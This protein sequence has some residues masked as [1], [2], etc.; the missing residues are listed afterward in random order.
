[1]QVGKK[2]SFNFKDS[3]NES[4]ENRGYNPEWLD[5]WFQVLIDAISA[6]KDRQWGKEEFAYL[7]LR[8]WCKIQK[9][10]LKAFNS[11]KA[12]LMPTIGQNNNLNSSPLATTVSASI[13]LPHTNKRNNRI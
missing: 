8:E 5:W 11:Q 2:K 7:G 4:K 13:Y 10:K 12:Q 1:M 6:S 9:H 3:N